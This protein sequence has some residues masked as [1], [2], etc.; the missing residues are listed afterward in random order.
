MLKPKDT[1]ILNPIF[2]ITNVAENQVETIS[3]GGHELEKE[4]Y[5]TARTIDNDLIIFIE[6]NQLQSIPITFNVWDH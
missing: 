4:S 2:I 5:Q 1:P 6:M 3:L